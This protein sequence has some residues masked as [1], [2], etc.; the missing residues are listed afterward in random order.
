MLNKSGTKI[1]NRELYVSSFSDFKCLPDQILD[2]K[3]HF[4]KLL[5]NN[6]STLH[7]K[8]YPYELLQV[9]HLI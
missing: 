2:D 5:N 8:L 1:T 4:D 3:I 9:S 7:C 6:I